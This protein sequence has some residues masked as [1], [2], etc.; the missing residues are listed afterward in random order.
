MLGNS[1]TWVIVG[2]GS[3]FKLAVKF[4]DVKDCASYSA[5]DRPPW[6]VASRWTLSSCA[7][8]LNKMKAVLMVAGMPEE[9][10][11]PPCAHEET[12]AADACRYFALCMYVLVISY[13]PI[14]P[15]PAWIDT[16]FPSLPAH[17]V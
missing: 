9:M 10:R 2:R 4:E 17:K 14:R 7:S 12:S 13:R 1:A 16:V 6:W 8:S 5:M 11:C 15:R 3:P